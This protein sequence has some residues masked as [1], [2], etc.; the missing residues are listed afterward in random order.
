M[1]TPQKLGGKSGFEDF[2]YNA[3]IK[4]NFRKYLEISER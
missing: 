4:D 3:Y 2:K 1:H